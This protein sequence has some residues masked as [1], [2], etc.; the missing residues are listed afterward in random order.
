ALKDSGTI[1]MEFPHLLNIIKDNQFDTINH[2]H[3]SYLSFQTEKIIFE[4][5]DLKLYDVEKLSTHGGSLRVYA[6]HSDNSTFKATEN[7]STIL[8]EERDFG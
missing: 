8:V 1:T 5:Q 2:E 6:T 3:I 7:I 4:A